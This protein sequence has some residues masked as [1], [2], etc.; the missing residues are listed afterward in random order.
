MEGEET[1][2]MRDGMEIYRIGRNAKC[3][4]GVH[5][6]N[7]GLASVPSRDTKHLSF[8]KTLLHNFVFLVNDVFGSTLGNKRE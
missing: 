4:R 1:E 5:P 6:A 3:R 7:A 2:K 8:Q